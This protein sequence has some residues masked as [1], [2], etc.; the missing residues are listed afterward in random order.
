ML[1]YS[2]F[3]KSKKK[4]IIKVKLAAANVIFQS[5]ASGIYSHCNFLNYNLLIHGCQSS[6][7]ISFFKAASA[8]KELSE[9][10]LAAAPP[11]R[12]EGCFLVSFFTE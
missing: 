4:R 7:L 6:A 1:I 8:P 12:G 9:K 2:R 10:L 11:A 5:A 3:L